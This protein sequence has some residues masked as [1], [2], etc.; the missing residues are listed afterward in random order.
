MGRVHHTIALGGDC[1][2][3]EAAILDFVHQWQVLGEPFG[4]VGTNEG[5][6]VSLLS[7]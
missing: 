3:V 5:N 7:P 4:K 2:E 1:W 6:D